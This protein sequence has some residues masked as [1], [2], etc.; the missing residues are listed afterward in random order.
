MG[1]KDGIS[2]CND[3][4]LSTHCTSA[5]V[6]GDKHLNAIK[7]LP[8]TEIPGLIFICTQAKHTQI[9]GKVRKNTGVAADQMSQNSKF[10]VS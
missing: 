7:S 8:G 4:A 10:S 5:S 9:P 3:L 2:P 1:I 6:P